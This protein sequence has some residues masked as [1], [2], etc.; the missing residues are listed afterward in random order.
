MKRRVYPMLMVNM[1]VCNKATIVVLQ[2]TFG[3]HDGTVEVKHRTVKIR[4]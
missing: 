1:R 2:A 4:N 3:H